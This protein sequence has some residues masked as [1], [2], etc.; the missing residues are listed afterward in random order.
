MV[1][2][3]LSGWVYIGKPCLLLLL[4]YI[5]FKDQFNSHFDSTKLNRPD[6][7]KLV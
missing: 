6:G 4:L 5:F 7:E 3:H 2:G 1:K